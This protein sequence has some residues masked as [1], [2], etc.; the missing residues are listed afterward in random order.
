[1]HRIRALSE[2][3]RMRVS[4][5]CNARCHTPPSDALSKKSRNIWPKRRPGN[6]VSAF[7]A[8]R[9]RPCRACLRGHAPPYLAA[10]ITPHMRHR[11]TP[12]LHL[13]HSQESFSERDKACF[14]TRPRPSHLPAPGTA[15]PQRPCSPTSSPPRRARRPRARAQEE[16][17]RR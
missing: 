6:Q 7:S 2:H 14:L 12:V 13:H 15:H 16:K 11:L 10:L 8:C 17:Y 1:M 5:T 3:R 9:A 4:S